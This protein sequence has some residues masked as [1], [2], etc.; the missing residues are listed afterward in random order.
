MNL[1]IHQK[2]TR[3]IGEKKV[4][5]LGSTTQ[6]STSRELVEA[7]QARMPNGQELEQEAGLFL[8][9]IKESKRAGTVA[10][11]E[12]E[13]RRRRVLV[14]QQRDQDL[15]EESALEEVLVEKL[16]RESEEA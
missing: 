4:R 11:K 15:L 5:L 2:T 8:R 14:E 12:R 6:A 3:Q 7:I 16:S 9:K 13:R 1:R 10:R